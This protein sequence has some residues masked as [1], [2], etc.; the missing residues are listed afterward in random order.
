MTSLVIVLALLLDVLLGEPRRWHPLVGFGQLATTMENL[1]RRETHSAIRQ[2]LFGAF[3]WLLL[4]LVPTLALWQ[5]LSFLDKPLLIAVEVLVL[6]LCIGNRSLAEHA[7]AVA[8]PLLAADLDGA[9]GAVAMIVSRDTAALDA[10]GAT[11]ATV[12]SVLENGSD[13]VLAPLFWFALVGAPGALLY[14]LANTLD[15]RWGYRSARYLHFGRTAARLDDALNWLPAR[16]CALAYGLA[17]NLRDALRCWYKQAPQAASP[18]AG[19]VMAAG[20]GA[21][22]IVLGGPAVYH[23]KEEWRPQLGSG[24]E[25][26]PADIERALGLLWRALILWLV[27]LAAVEWLAGLPLRGTIPWP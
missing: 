25:A 8:R 7:R 12:E 6:Y 3:A 13:G 9:R 1:L 19:P 18:N 26:E 10:S 20:A 21:L 22:G 23:G 14:R 15:A 2:Q 27:V 16:L 24:R 11:R 5:L 4:V 17:G